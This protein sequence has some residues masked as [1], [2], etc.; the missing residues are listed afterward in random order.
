MKKSL[1]ALIGAIF[2]VCTFVASSATAADF[3]PPPPV[4]KATPAPYVAPATWDG[5][6]IGLNA[7]YSWGGEREE[8]RD[9]Y[10][11]RYDRTIEMPGW[12]V[13][14]QVGANKQFGRWFV[15]GVESDIQWT[16]QSGSSKETECVWMKHGVCKKTHTTVDE[17]T[18][19]WFG[20]ARVRAGF[21]ALE[22]MLVYG[23]V[24]GAY[25]GLTNNHR[26]WYGTDS[27]NPYMISTKQAVVGLAWGG[28]V[29]WAFAQNWS[30]KLEYLR[31][32]LHAIETRT[33]K[34]SGGNQTYYRET[35]T[36]D[37]VRVGI[38]Y[39]F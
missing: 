9:K 31:L 12:L 6:Y 4:Y 29:E 28:G 36:D 10:V 5:L 35:L 32:D 18:L 34:K 25:G 23:T 30:A 1:F 27:S 8:Y 15:F 13:G 38:N 33:G 26:S 22:R 2:A 37:I 39:R 24:G 16:N 14:A 20:T 19:D 11:P 7:G 17:P 21:L 3:R